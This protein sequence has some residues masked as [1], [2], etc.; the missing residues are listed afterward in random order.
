MLECIP[1][2]SSVKVY[3]EHAAIWNKKRYLLVSYS[4][5]C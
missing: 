3:E 2:D 4:A 5:T 1:T